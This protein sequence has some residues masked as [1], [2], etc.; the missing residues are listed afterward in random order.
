[1]FGTQATWNDHDGTWVTTFG[2]NPGVGLTNVRHSVADHYFRWMNSVRI[3]F[4]WRNFMMRYNNSMKVYIRIN[5]FHSPI[6]VPSSLHPTPGHGKYH[7]AT[8]HSC[9]VLIRIDWIASHGIVLPYSFL[10][11]SLIQISFIGVGCGCCVPI[12]IT[13]GIV[14][15]HKSLSIVRCFIVFSCLFPALSPTP[16]HQSAATS[17]PISWRSSSRGLTVSTKS[18]APNFLHFPAY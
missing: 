1:M 11:Y 8:G 9:F 4:Y 6:V 14:W 3:A 12:S 18:V 13:K 10:L 16:A 7:P 15:Y 17:P 2:K 5:M